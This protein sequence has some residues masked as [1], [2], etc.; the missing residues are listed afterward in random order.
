MASLIEMK[1][2]RIA[3]LGSVEPKTED[4]FIDTIGY[5]IFG[6]IKF[7]MSLKENLEKED[8]NQLSIPSSSL[9]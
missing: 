4:E 3:S 9:P 6:L 7:K 2:N 1:M 5:C 8:P